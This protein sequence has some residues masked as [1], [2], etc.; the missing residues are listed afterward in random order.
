MY[1]RKLY[2]MLLENH[3]FLEAIHTIGVGTNP[4]VGISPDRDSFA[5]T[6]ASNPTPGFV[7]RT[8]S[9]VE[10]GVQLAR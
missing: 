10:G 9:G 6:P 4:G 2:G 3:A 1:H 7:S 8:E 5:R